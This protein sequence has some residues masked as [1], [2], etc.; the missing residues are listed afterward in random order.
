MD[1]VQAIAKALF[2]TEPSKFLLP[3]PLVNVQQVFKFHMAA[4]SM[5]R[6]HVSVV[7]YSFILT[8][9]DPIL[10]FYRYLWVSTL[11]YALA[12]VFAFGPLAF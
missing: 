7:E 3:G 5:L 2:G 9:S 6:S 10:R 11:I 8:E 1:E 12:A 4:S